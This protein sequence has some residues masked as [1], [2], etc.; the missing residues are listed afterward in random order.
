[1]NPFATADAAFAGTSSPVATRA[2]EANA[3]NPYLTIAASHA[4]L[5]TKVQVVQAR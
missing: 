4:G 3:R 1:V 2:S 5:V